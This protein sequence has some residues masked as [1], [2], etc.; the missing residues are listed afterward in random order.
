MEQHADSPESSRP[1]GA[2][3]A[4][5]R[6]EGGA[7]ASEHKEER[8]DSE[9]LIDA[10]NR[11]KLARVKEIIQGMKTNGVDINHQDSDGDTASIWACYNGRKEVVLELLKVDGLDVNIQSR[12]GYTALMMA[13]VS[14]SLE[15]VIELL[16]VDGLK[17]NL[18]SSDG[19]TAL[20]WACSKCNTDIALA[21][22]RV[23]P[24]VDR[25]IT[26]SDGSNA[27]ACARS[28]GLT[29][30]VTLIEALDRGDERMPLV[31]VRHRYLHGDGT[32]EGAQAQAPHPPGSAITKALVDKYLVHYM[33]R[34]LAP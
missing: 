13:C 23:R 34:F 4:T 30:V 7:S 22:L 20:T 15:V 18:Q 3:P 5:S 12:N 25:H 26:H 6:A 11:S 14:N 10:A 8:L 9:A 16:K 33:S 31:K 24:R 21:L 2:E 29:A 19:R 32:T 17:V 28:K 27:L 1:D